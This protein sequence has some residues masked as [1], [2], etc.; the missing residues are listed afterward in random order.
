[1]IERRHQENGETENGGGGWRSGQQPA[2]AARHPWDGK[3]QEEAGEGVGKGEDRDDLGRGHDGVVVVGSRR[4]GQRKGRAA[5]KRVSC[6]ADTRP[7][8][9]ECHQCAEQQKPRTE[10]EQRPGV[11]TAAKGGGIDA[12]PGRPR[13]CHKLH[14]PP[15]AGIILRHRV[16]VD[17]EDPVSR[18]DA[19]VPEHTLGKHP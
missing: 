9:A 4:Q 12:H 13:A 5:K 10:D 18:A 3:G 16:P 17:G 14:N 8:R 11:V 6:R 1:V 15:V 7:R 19:A 2:A